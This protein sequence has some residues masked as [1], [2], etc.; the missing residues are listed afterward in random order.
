MY[1]RFFDARTLIDINL[2]TL[3]IMAVLCFISDRRRTFDR[4]AVG[5]VT[6][7]LLINYIL[8]RS[9]STLPELKPALPSV[10]AYLFFAFELMTVSYTLF[11]IVV[12]TRAT[13][14]AAR[15]DRGEAMLR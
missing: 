13:D 9:T 5:A 6:A 2:G 15:A 12:L 8:W 1:E 3:V 11:S 4:I 14:H 10:W 7:L